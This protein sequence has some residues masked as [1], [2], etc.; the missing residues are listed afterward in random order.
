M[1]RDMLRVVKSRDGNKWY[2]EGVNAPESSRF[3]MVY[4]D[5]NDPFDPFVFTFL[6][7]SN[8]DTFIKSMDDASILN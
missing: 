8:A 3:Y 5:S 4:R 6:S 2:L 7:H 1:I